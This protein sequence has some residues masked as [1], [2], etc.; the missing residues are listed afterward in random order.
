MRLARA[1]GRRGACGCGGRREAKGTGKAVVNPL[2]SEMI[3]V[4]SLTE[5][6]VCGQRASFRNIFTVAKRNRADKKW[7][8]F[9]GVLSPF[10]SD[11]LS[12]P[13]PGIPQPADFKSVSRPE[14]SLIR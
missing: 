9:K 8:F 14:R 2:T 10:S 1:G 12:P 11:I 5:A 4:D 13:P 6:C 7:E 3:P